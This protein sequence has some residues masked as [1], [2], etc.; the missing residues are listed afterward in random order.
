MQPEQEMQLDTISK[1][2]A[3]LANR[4]WNQIS[5]RSIGTSGTQSLSDANMTMM[6]LTAIHVTITHVNI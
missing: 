6:L 4:N 2:A 3:Y 1:M 5:G